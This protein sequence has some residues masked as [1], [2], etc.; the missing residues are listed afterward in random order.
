MTTTSHHRHPEHQPRKT[1]PGRSSGDL[2]DPVCGMHV[3][4]DAPESATYQGTLYRFCSRKCAEAF[5]NDPSKY[6]HA[7][8]APAKATVPSTGVIYTCP[9]HPQIRQPR[10][11]NC[12]I[13]GMALEPLT[14]TAVEE[15][16][17]ELR[18]MTRR[19]WVGL[20]L[21]VPLLALAMGE[22]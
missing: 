11:G 16:N 3:S 14:P 15:E 18:N 1:E 5:R 20:V 10:P 4:A 6:V 12:P 2:I 9:M 22:G 7:S 8:S 13:C 19:F 17:P 21:S